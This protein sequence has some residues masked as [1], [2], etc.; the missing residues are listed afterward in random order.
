MGAAAAL[1]CR[2]DAP[3]PP[4]ERSALGIPA[5][6]A[7]VLVL[8]QN[9]HLDLNWLQTTDGYYD[10]FVDQIYEDALDAIAAD[11]DYRYATAEM[12]YLRRW[13]ERHPDRQAEL[14]AALASGRFRVVGGGVSQPDVLLPHDELLFADYREGRRWVRSIGGEP[15]RAAYLPDSFGLSRTTP[16]LLDAM[17]FDAVAF[18]RAD[19]SNEVPTFDASLADFA[20]T[21]VTPG[22]NAARLTEAG[23]VDFLWQGSGGGTVLGTWLAWGYMFGDYVDYDRIPFRT[24]PAPLAAPLEDLDAVADNLQ[25]AIDILGPR[26]PTTSMFLPIGG[27]FQV[28]KPRLAEYARYWNETRYPETGVWV[29]AGSYADHADLALAEVEKLQRFSFD[30]APYWMGF[31]ASRPQVKEDARRAAAALVQADAIAAAVGAPDVEGKLDGLWWAAARSDHHD[32]VTGTSVDL[33]TYGE[34]VPEIGAARRQAG[35]IVDDLVRRLA[36][37]RAAAGQVLV[38]DTETSRLPSAVAIHASGPEHPWL[39]AADGE[40]YPGQW[41][42]GALWFVPPPQPFGW[43]AY[44]VE[45]GAPAPAFAAASARCAPPEGPGCDPSGRV[46]V[47]TDRLAVAFDVTRGG[48]I[49]SLSGDGVQRTDGPS[50][51]LRLADDDGGL[52]TFGHEGRPACDTVIRE[53][54]TYTDTFYEVEAVGPALLRVAFHFRVDGMPFVRKA[55]FTQGSPALELQTDADVERGV[56]VIEA[57]E[58]PANGAVVR[59]ASPGGQLERFASTAEDPVWHAV[60]R[61]FDREGMFGGLSFAAAGNP[62]MSFDDDGSLFLVVHRVP[63]GSDCATGGASGTT[64]GRYVARVMV[65]P[66]AAG[67]DPWTLTAA[68]WAP[69]WGAMSSGPGGG[70]SGALLDVELPPGMRVSSLRSRDGATTLRVYRPPGVEACVRLNREAGTWRR[71]QDEGLTGEPESCVV[72][73]WGTWVRR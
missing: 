59:M 39:R 64:P 54:L 65:V 40:L 48:E 18:W 35:V 27:D 38:V 62:A 49:L 30:F 21:P 20:S 5:D 52:Y 69:L 58:S 32:Y 71:V 10:L 51:S 15:S 23:V 42:D 41:M 24:A 46:D 57:W 31:Y 28:P 1:A 14:E 2:P 61:W 8:G 3:P 45:E 70:G 37:Q 55:T 4:T 73:S 29:L 7:R 33:V 13:H 12:D 16:D 68:H 22:T 44:T 63:G 9:A 43:A 66:H 34:Q 72:G 19:G 67:V 47:V 26:S 6:A 11:P 60:G 17:G 25:D 56:M 50:W 53:K 36:D